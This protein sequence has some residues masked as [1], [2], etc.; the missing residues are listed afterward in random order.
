MV[1]SLDLLFESMI[2]YSRS[3][4]T[5]LLQYALSTEQ[6]T[7]SVHLSLILTCY[8]SLQ[9]CHDS[10]QIKIVQPQ[11]DLKPRQNSKP[12]LPVS[13]PVSSR[14]RIL[15]NLLTIGSSS[16]KLKSLIRHLTLLYFFLGSS[17]WIC[18]AKQIMTCAGI[19]W[20]SQKSLH[21]NFTEIWTKAIML[22][23]GGD[24]PNE[25]RKTPGKST[26]LL[27]FYSH[28]CK[29]GKKYDGEEFLLH[30]LQ[31]KKPFYSAAL[32]QFFGLIPETLLKSCLLFFMF[33]S[34]AAVLL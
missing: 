31:I 3:M 10:S 8:P 17:V 15:L 1:L 7:M 19:T 12:L 9:S 23:S 33:T 30:T 34:P 21:R 28:I 16:K 14:H 2:T 20:S 27:L 25:P 4:L 24:N 5:S 26:F 13:T 6:I 32:V 29:Q 11:Q 18:P 22:W